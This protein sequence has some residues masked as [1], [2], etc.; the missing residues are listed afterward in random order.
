MKKQFYLL[1]TLLAVVGLAFTSCSQTYYQVYDVNSNT[2]KQQDN[3]LVYENND[4][5][6]MYNLWGMN[7]RVGFIVQNKTASDL[8]V[9]LGQTFFIFNGAANDYF[10]NREY[11]TTTTESSSLQYSFAASYLASG[12]LWPENYYVPVTESIAAKLLKGRSH[13]VTTKEQQIICVPAHAYK[14]ISEYKVSPQFMKT[15]NKEKDFPKQTANVGYYSESD[16][17]IKFVNRIAYSF[18]K[19]VKNVQFLDHDFYVTSVTNYSESAA[20][21]K[22]KEKVDCY[23][24]RK[25]EIERFKI[26]GPNKFYKSYNASRTHHIVVDR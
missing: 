21:E 12:L 3:A 11:N 22:V 5:K 8:Y 16:S 2:L 7:G 19:D 26:G 13:G 1:V 24:S 6:V 15:C 9:D 20:I 23:D 18:D 17:P 10:K 25:T 14:V 4:L